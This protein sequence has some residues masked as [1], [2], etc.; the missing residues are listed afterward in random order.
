MEDYKSMGFENKEQYMRYK[1]DI[2]DYEWLIPPFEFPLGVSD[3][4]NMTKKQAQEYFD[5]F[6]PKIPE[7]VEYLRNRCAKD[8]S[9]SVKELDFSPDSL[10]PLWVWFL[11]IAK[12]EKMPDE[13][14]AK[15]QEHFGHLKVSAIFENDNQLSVVTQFIIRDIGMYLGKVFTD[16][17]N[18]ITWNYLAKPKRDI[19][20]N[21][22]Q[23]FGFVDTNYTP[24][25]EL[26][27]E[28]IHKTNVQ[29][30]K[31]ISNTQKETDLYD[32]VMRFVDY[33]PK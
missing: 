21:K 17:Y 20:V 10:K 23:L 14:L 3:L 33:V 2:D 19:H 18:S 11:K 25:F 16:N 24:P 12:V 30:G 13:L 1:N 6:I 31:L 15:R 4:S 22:P 32:I 8:L 7:R 28:P 5:W 9:I 27:F 26:T 29:A